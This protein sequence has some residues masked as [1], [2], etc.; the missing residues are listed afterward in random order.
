VEEVSIE[1][2]YG[3]RLI[4]TSLA[5][6]FC[7]GLSFA[8]FALAAADGEFSVAALVS[9]AVGAFLATRARSILAEN[10]VGAD[11]QALA[12]KRVVAKRS[13]IAVAS[14]MII[15]AIVGAVV[16]RA[17]Q[18][19]ASQDFGDVFDATEQIEGIARATCDGMSSTRRVDVWAIDPVQ[20]DDQTILVASAGLSTKIPKRASRSDFVAAVAD[21]V[22]G[23]GR[24]LCAESLES[25][26][27]IGDDDLEAANLRL[28]E[29]LAT[30]DTSVLVKPL[31]MTME[32]HSLRSGASAEATMVFFGMC[33]DSGEVP[34]RTGSYVATPGDSE[35]L[36][37]AE[38]AISRL[39]P[40]VQR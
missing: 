25:A 36:A 33:N 11:A 10:P 40:L 37:L 38:L 17:D 28:C 20:P 16:I 7:I 5:A 32:A 15:P 35:W 9:L 2:D 22:E 30:P 19:A 29:E 34:S 24:L 4:A 31:T 18:A 39:S 26:E 14:L 12:R 23:S 6:S 8:L 27:H 3:S 1:T 21:A 13:G